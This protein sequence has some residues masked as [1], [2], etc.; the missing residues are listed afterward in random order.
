MDVLNLPLKDSV[1]RFTTL[2]FLRIFKF[3]VRL[4][5]SPCQEIDILENCYNAPLLYEAGQRRS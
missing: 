2:L 3:F 5:L 1:F 4:V